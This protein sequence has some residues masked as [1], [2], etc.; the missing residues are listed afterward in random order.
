MFD[1]LP[2]PTPSLMPVQYYGTSNADAGG[3][4]WA[5]ISG[6]PVPTR[7]ATASYNTQSAPCFTGNCEITMGDGS[8]KCVKDLKKD[9]LVF[10]SS[11]PYNA[12][13][14]AKS[15]VVCVLETRFADGY[16]NLV[17]L[18]TGLTITEWHPIFHRGKWTFPGDVQVA[19]NQPCKAV[20]SLVLDSNHIVFINNMPCICLGHKY[21]TGILKHDY[22]GSAAVIDDLKQMPGWD[23]G[24]I[25]NS[26]GAC[27]IIL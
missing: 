21:K 26:A 4:M 11:D 19:T 17:N 12:R 8:T 9:D 15:R 10:S 16:T 24:K 18:K 7:A 25:I 14:N 2:P 27:G 6:F 5:G 3:P 20:Y 23:K 22:F 13:P 1:S